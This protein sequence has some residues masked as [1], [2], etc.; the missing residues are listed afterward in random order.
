MRTL[1]KSVR[2]YV[3]GLGSGGELLD[4]KAAKSTFVG[5]RLAAI[6]GLRGSGEG[7]CR[8]ATEL[9]C[10]CNE[11]KFKDHAVFILGI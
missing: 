3:R 4:N 5:L 10:L 1:A 9:I 2:S 6:P 7:D 8:L 11:Q